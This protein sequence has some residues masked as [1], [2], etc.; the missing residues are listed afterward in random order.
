MSF[1][2]YAGK[3][4]Y[5]TGGSSGIG[6]AAARLFSSLGAHVVIFARDR[7]RGEAAR[8]EIERARLSESQSVEYVSLDVSR[9]DDVAAVM[10]KTVAVSGPPDVLI[11]SAG[12]QYPDYFEKIPS[13]KFD[14]MLGTNFEGTWNMIASLVPHMKRKGGHIVTVSSIAGIIGVFGY[15][16]YSATKFAVIGFSESLRSELKRYGITVSVLCPPDTDTPGLAEEN[17]TKPAETRAIAGNAGIMKPD[18]VARAL[19]AGM[20]RGTFLIIPGFEGK[21]VCFA[22]R[23]L[24]RLVEFMMDRD[25]RRVARRSGRLQA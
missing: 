1:R 22:K 4:V 11:T 13:E 5:I 15:T 7:E 19:V 25:I 2:S 9:R 6:L 20:E 17:R 12:I 18:D 24:P 16:A 21:F 3:A 8:R 23:L 10:E 14:E